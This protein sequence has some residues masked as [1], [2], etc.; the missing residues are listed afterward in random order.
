MKRHAS[1]LPG[2]PPSP[3]RLKSQE[4]VDSSLS[5]AELQ[6]NIRGVCP[7]VEAVFGDTSMTGL[8]FLLRSSVSSPHAPRYKLLLTDG[9]LWPLETTAQTMGLSERVVVD[10][11][12]SLSSS[13]RNF[14]VT[15]APAALQSLRRG[16]ET[17]AIELSDM[18][19]SES[20]FTPECSRDLH[21]A[22][23]LVETILHIVSPL[24]ESIVE[25]LQCRIRRL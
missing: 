8:D 3:S 13:S 4:P 19:S 11:F 7:V 6:V 2:S 20:S 10:A 14:V 22:Q 18:S 24:D 16:L 1:C 23:G 12:M 21:N 15:G 25:R 17:L 9:R 5:S